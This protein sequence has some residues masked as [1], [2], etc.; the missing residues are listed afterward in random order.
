MCGILGGINIPRDSFDS[1]KHL[2]NHRGPDE[3]GEFLS[4]NLFLYHS[5]LAIQDLISNKISI[6]PE[7]R[8]KILWYL[9]SLEIWYERCHKT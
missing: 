7:K 9:L 1:S 8:A 4:G 6:S 2:L 3:N 5:R